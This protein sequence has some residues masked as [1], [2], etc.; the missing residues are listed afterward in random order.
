MTQT[1]RPAYHLSVPDNWKNDPQRPIYLD[2]EYLYYYLYNADY[3]NGG[4]GTAWRLAT[5][6]DHVAFTDHG[7]AIPKF[8]NGNGDCWSGSVVVDTRGTAGYGRG[9]VIALVTQAP[10]G[11]Q[12]Q[13]LWYSTDKG[14]TFRAGGTDPVLANPGVADFRDPKVIWDDERAHWV[15]ANAEGQ[16]IGFYVSEDLRTWNEVG[17]FRCDDL[18]VLEC[19]DLFRMRAE[20]GT[21][22]WV[23]GM[24]AN[25][26]ARGLPATYA[27]WTGAFDGAAFAADSGEP[28]WLDHGFDFYGA[29]TYAH[30]DAHGAEDPTLRHA[31]GWANFWDYPDN[32]P[33]MVTDGYNGDDMI[34]RDVRLKHRGGA[35][36]LVSSPTSALRDH[37]RRTRSLGDVHV[38]GVL[39][40]DVSARS[41]ELTCE[42]VWDPA[43]PPT[44]IGMELCRAPRGGRHV[45]VGAFLE[46]GY[47]YVNRRPTFSPTGGESQTLIDSASGRLQVRVLVDHASVELFVGEGEA[48]HSHRVFP[49]ATDDRIRLFTSDGE[50]TFAE[51]RIAELAV[52]T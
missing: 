50:A 29:V 46:G 4:G 6:K 21:W 38:D 39:D 2:G 47:A 9:T 7:V 17:E 23:L 51:L 24:S 16:R 34:V 18:G 40:L 44:N 25:G 28:Q 5:T 26:K 27:Y 11:R 45:A 52:R 35:Y 22:R 33:S 30:H 3:L 43:A 15:M 41:Y 42:L 49:L 32:A 48:V 31:L 37:V 36:R 8:S 19:P 20:D 13:Y 1:Y 10:D 12:A 14:R